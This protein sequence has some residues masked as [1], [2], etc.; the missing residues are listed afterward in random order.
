MTPTL[1]QIQAAFNSLGVVSVHGE[2]RFRCPFCQPDETDHNEYRGTLSCGSRRL[3]VSL[4]WNCCSESGVVDKGLYK[5]WWRDLM[6]AYPLLDSVSVAVEPG[7]ARRLWSCLPCARLPESDSHTAAPDRLHAIYSDLLDRL[8]LVEYQGKWLEKR[9]LD[10]HWC[11]GAGYRS[12]DSAPADLGSQMWLEWGLVLQSVP[13]F[14]S[15]FGDRTRVLLRDRAIL[16]PCRNREGQIVALKQRLMASGSKKGRMRYF[17]GRS[18]PKAVNGVHFPLGCGGHKW[19]RIW[20]TEGER[21]ADCHWLR[22]GE[23]TI[24]IP[25]V[26]RWRSALD[27]ARSIAAP[28]ADVV[29]ALDRDKAGEGAESKLSAEFKREG[30]RVWRAE[31]GE[32]KG[33]DDAIAKNLEVSV[34]EWNEQG[35]TPDWIVVHEQPQPTIDPNSPSPPLSDYQILPYLQKR[36]PMLRSLLRCHGYTLDKLIKRGDVKWR[37]SPKGQVVEAVV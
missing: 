23:A 3:V 9:G 30:W 4:C 5:S 12:T 34:V 33:L 26:Q 2:C 22:K 17:G 18:G 13:G 19:D 15:V 16:I 25:G 37:L 28:G 8:D 20:V 1:D 14:D 6:Q 31:W 21:K 36:G 7:E 24:A 35:A 11:Y 32:G 29:L 27:A 10:S